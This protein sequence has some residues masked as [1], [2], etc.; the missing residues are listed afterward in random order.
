MRLHALQSKCGGDMLSSLLKLANVAF[1]HVKRTVLR[2]VSFSAEKG[3]FM[4]LL[5]VHGAAKSTL[6]DI[7][8]GF[9]K[10]DLGAV[11]ISAKSQKFGRLREI[12]QRVSHLPQSV[13]VNLPCT[14]EQL[15]AMVLAPIGRPYLVRAVGQR[16]PL[17][18]L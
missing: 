5:S 13:N 16:R 7:I 6:L 4:A 15:V 10:I 3:E 1:S 12:A 2:S 8:A 14:A 18:E 11:A 17:E 9:R